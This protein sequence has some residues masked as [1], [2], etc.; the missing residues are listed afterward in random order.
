MKIRYF[1]ECNKYFFRFLRG[2]CH[3]FQML[4]Q[5]IDFFSLEKLAGQGQ[6]WED[7]VVTFEECSAK[8]F[9]IFSIKSNCF[10]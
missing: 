5:K 3:N 7:N 10:F 2:V 9:Y 4:E 1:S 6:K 8:R